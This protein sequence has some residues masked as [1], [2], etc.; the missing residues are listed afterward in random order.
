MEI[1]I[2][3]KNRK[4][5]MLLSNTRIYNSRKYLLILLLLFCKFDI[6]WT[7][8][9]TLG[10]FV[11]LTGSWPAGTKSASAAVMAID[12]INNDTNLLPNERLMLEVWDD[13]CDAHASVGGTAEFHYGVYNNKQG[14]DAY[15]GPHCSDGCIPAGLLAAYFNKP[16][17][18]YSCSGQDLSNK[19]L[20]PTFARTKTFARSNKSATLNYLAELLTMFNWKLVTLIVSKQPAWHNTGQILFERLINYGIKVQDKFSYE[21]STLTDILQKAKKTARSKFCFCCLL[22]SNPLNYW[23]YH[24]FYCYYF[25]QY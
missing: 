11:P 18:A 24:H 19:V 3:N 21:P 23:H 8:N 16:M 13:K 15:I 22:F 1:N 5:K 25:Y 4:T 7:K 17:I 10:L 12:D 9:L 20:Y 2:E 14:V 6:A